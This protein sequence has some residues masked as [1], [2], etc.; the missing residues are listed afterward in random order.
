MIVAEVVA[1]TCLVFTVA[2]A[3]TPEGTT[4]VRFEGIFEDH[5]PRSQ[6]EYVFTLS[7][8][9]RRENLPKLIQVYRQTPSVLYSYVDG[10]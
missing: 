2:T 8:L 5:S 7:R 9:N 10:N 1:V 4:D 6:R 3:S